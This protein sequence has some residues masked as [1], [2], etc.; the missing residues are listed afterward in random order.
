MST[1]PVVEN[2]PPAAPNQN[3]KDHWAGIEHEI[4]EALGRSE[5]DATSVKRLQVEMGAAGIVLS[6]QVFFE[7]ERDMAELVTKAHA[8]CMRVVNRV[9][10][11]GQT[12][13]PQVQRPAPSSA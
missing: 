7:W 1:Q 8:H 12:R 10:V 13:A 6:G 4:L 5:I 9:T 2:Q 11:W 3:L